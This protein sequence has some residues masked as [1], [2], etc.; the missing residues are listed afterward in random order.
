MSTEAASSPAAGN[1]EDPTRT[2]QMA[3]VA[4]GARIGPYVLVRQIGEGGMGAVYH[5]QQRE[6]IRR[7]VALKI[8]KPGMDSKQVIAR[9]ES[10]RQALAVMDHPNVAHVLD[11]GT[12]AAGLPY[13]VMELVD[14]VPITCYCDS[15]SLTVRERVGLFIA[16]CHAIQH[17]HQKGIIH[18]DIK[19]SNILVA[20]QESKPAPKV[21]DFGLAKALGH[22][23]SDATM[24]T[25]LG[26]VVGTLDYMSPEQAELTRHDIDTRSD[27]YSLGAV[28]YELLTGTKPLERE[29]L[30]NGGYFEALRRIRDEETVPPSA[31]VRS[32]TTL[33]EIAA[34]RKSDPARLRKLLHRELDWIAMKALEKD[35]TRRYET[36]NGLARDLERYLA[37]EPVEAAPPSATYR[38]G[39]FVRK[40]RTLLAT[41]A[42]FT[43]LLLGGITISTIEARRAQRR[44]GQVRELA[45]NF[46]FQFYDQVTPLPGSTAVRASIVE[47]A[48]KYLDGLAGEAGNDKGLLFELAQAYQRLGEVQGSQGKAS[49]GQVEEARRSFQRSLDLY[50]R[51][52]VNRVSPAEWRR[53]AARMLLTWAQMEY[54][55]AHSGA[56]E[57]LARR[58]MPLVEGGPSDDQTRLVQV[59]AERRLAEIRLRSGGPYEAVALLDSAKKILLDLQASGKGGRD[60]ADQIATTRDELARARVRVGDLDEALSSFQELIQ[61]SEPCDE[62]AP[63]R[64]PC[65]SLA[66][67][68]SWAADVYGA[69]DRPNLG[70]PDKAVPLYQQSIRI[71]ERLAAQDAQDRKTRFD[72]A[73]RYGKLGDVLWRADPQRALELYA[74]AL[75]TTEALV[76]K[77]QASLLRDS[78]LNAISRPL[79]QLGRKTEARRALTELLRQGSVVSAP[80]DYEDRLDNLAIRT[81]WARLLAAEGKREEAQHVLDELIQSGEAL[82]SSHP[83]DLTAVFVL[84]NCYRELAG[85]TTGEKRRRALLQSAAGWHSWPATSFTRREEQR[86]LAAAS[87]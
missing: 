18:R 55:Q 15:K 2:I 43:A 42:A 47:T 27:V 36:V 12:T 24:M 60:L 30:A 70:Q 25:N 23:L 63:P 10:E 4:P 79:I 59:L 11:A 49:L 87:R 8:I 50:A 73:A 57:A 65:R 1:P 40:H 45:N 17:A 52:P 9:F 29:H 48:R 74:R 71:L 53:N 5:A 32:S 44:F 3:G 7:D 21:I 26:T 72:L 76:S 85:I 51:L 22:Q 33:V 13:F 86:D 84:A 14:G 37:G 68:L 66:V 31:R 67:R 78:Y 62:N 64:Q 61:S 38:M 20:E 80:Q 19:P 81:L 56:A 75:T 34:L 41:A 82:R 46:L 28:L 35:R 58:A 77:E 83:N 6:P 39:K 54:A 16:V 69:V